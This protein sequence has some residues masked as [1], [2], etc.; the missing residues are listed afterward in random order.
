[1][2]SRLD[3]NERN[4]AYFPGS[5]SGGPHDLRRLLGMMSISLSSKANYLGGVQRGKQLVGEQIGRH[6]IGSQTATFWGTQM[7]LLG[8]SWGC[9][10][11]DKNSVHWDGNV[12]DTVE[13]SS[14]DRN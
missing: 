1:M 9:K 6:F 12:V 13:S 11:G 8:Y 4:K 10:R 14:E 5:S 7:M 2:G 3:S